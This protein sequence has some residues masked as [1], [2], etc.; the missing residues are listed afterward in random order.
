MG[1][2]NI[3]ELFLFL[4]FHHAASRCRFTPVEKQIQTSKFI[5]SMGLHLKT[6]TICSVLG[7]HGCAG[8]LAPL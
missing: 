3:L 1:N 8:K 7:N 4:Q 5:L 6:A 2:A